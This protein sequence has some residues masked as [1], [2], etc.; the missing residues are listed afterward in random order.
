MEI[1]LEFL[2]GFFREKEAFPEPFGVSKH[3]RTKYYRDAVARECRNLL[4]EIVNL[5]LAVRY[6]VALGRRDLLWDLVPELIERNVLEVA[7]NAE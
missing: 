5:N 6:L 1:L 7:E 3:P 2:H 4:K